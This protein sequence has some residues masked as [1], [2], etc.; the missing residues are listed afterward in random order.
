VQ[1]RAA[2]AYLLEVRVASQRLGPRNVDV[3]PD[4]PPMLLQAGGSEMLSADTERY[5]AAQRA[6]G[7]RCEVQLWPGMF[8]VFQVGHRFLPEARAALDGVDRFVAEVKKGQVTRGPLS[9]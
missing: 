8:H 6:A 2:L 4:L 3:G 7:G 9:A 1:L 5:G